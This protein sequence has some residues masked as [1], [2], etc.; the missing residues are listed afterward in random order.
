MGKSPLDFD[1]KESFLGDILRNHMELLRLADSKANMLLVAS[2]LVLTLSL[3]YLLKEGPLFYGFLV[4]TFSTLTAATLALFVIIPRGHTPEGT[5]LMYFR[6][7]LEL[8]EENYIY[9]LKKTISDRERMVEEYGREI[10]KLG[11]KTLYIK[12]RSLKFALAIFLGGFLL[13]AAI[14]VFSLLVQ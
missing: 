13:G 3:Q 1:T 11:E 10:Y 14:V 4:I 12:Y 7:F 8:D 2:S 6:S 5:N 9:A